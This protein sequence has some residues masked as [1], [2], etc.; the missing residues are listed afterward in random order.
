MKKEFHQCKA[1]LSP[2][3]RCPN[4]CIYNKEKKEFS[5]W[6]VVHAE[7]CNV[8]N[9]DYKK[10][11]SG[12]ER[13]SC[14][15]ASELSK[16]KVEEY[17]GLLENCVEQRKIFESNCIFTDLQDKG[18]EQFI[19]NLNEKKRICEQYLHEIIEQIK[20]QEDQK[21]IRKEEAK[22]RRK[23][24]KIQKKR[25]KD[26]EKEAEQEAEQEAGKVEQM[27]ERDKDLPKEELILSE[28]ISSLQKK[29]SPQK[30]KGTGKG[31]GTSKKKEFKTEQE[32]LEE[33]IQEN[34]NQIQ[35]E[36]QKL[37]ETL[38]KIKK[39]DESVYKVFKDEKIP[40]V[41]QISDEN[42]TLKLD[43][44][45]EMNFNAL[46]TYELLIDKKLILEKL[47]K[48]VGA[49]SQKEMI[50]MINT[51]FPNEYQKEIKTL[52]YTI[53]QDFQN[54]N[55]KN[56]NLRGLDYYRMR[57]DQ[58]DP[59]SPIYEVLKNLENKIKVVFD[60][61]KR[62]DVK[63]DQ[64]KKFMELVMKPLPTKKSKK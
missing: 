5:N 25:E 20:I 19:Q 38:E 42:F 17:I 30:T 23:E 22:S 6:C 51:Y 21:R 48:S 49:N 37:L 35:K 12:N 13:W 63:E 61:K 64:I 45:M 58:L 8:L 52:I 24:I 53:F 33:A 14:S 1:F 3:I 62:P 44:L 41:N 32:I 54:E 47:S 46:K 27:E 26:A 34:K 11:C 60:L 59:S 10:S 18:H 7:N 43:Q 16:N 31:T 57:F 36:E 50:H 56:P 29:K 2:G 55:Q 39:I 40:Q 15:S 4:K 28:Q 9:N